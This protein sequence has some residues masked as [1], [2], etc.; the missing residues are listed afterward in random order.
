MFV[1]VRVN[2]VVLQKI[3]GLE[4]RYKFGVCDVVAH[5]LEFFLEQSVLFLVAWQGQV[6]GVDKKL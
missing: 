1:G 2:A 6:Y 3:I 4:S 5:L